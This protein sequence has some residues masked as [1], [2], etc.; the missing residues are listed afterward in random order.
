VAK[1]VEQG[2]RVR[3]QR[4]VGHV[5]FRQARCT[6]DQSRQRLYNGKEHEGRRLAGHRVRKAS[7]GIKNTSSWRRAAHNAPSIVYRESVCM[8][9]CLSL[10]V[11]VCVCVCIWAYLSVCVSVSVCLC[12]CVS[13]RKSKV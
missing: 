4:I 9:L 6:A 8:C 10:C 3:P 12:L 1:R 7:P 5:Q 11:C 2:R 13:V